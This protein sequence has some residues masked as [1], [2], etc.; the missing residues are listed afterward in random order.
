[1]SQKI[2]KLIKKNKN[3]FGLVLDLDY[4]KLPHFELDLSKNNKDFKNLDISSPR[5]FQDYIFKKL[6]QT[7]S[8]FAVGKYNENRCIYDHSNLFSG[9]QR[10]TIHLG[11]DLWVNART[12]VL[13]PF[14]ARAH[15]FNYN[16][17][18]G[19]YGPTIILEHEL[20][21]EKFFTLYGHLSLN[22]LKNIQRGKLFK[23][24][25]II[26]KVGNY[27]VNGNWAPHLHFELITDMQN[28][29][30]DYPGV[31]SIKKRKEFLHLCPNPNL[32]LQIK[33]LN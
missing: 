9:S 31:T 17:S 2:V 22:S 27:P 30:G 6:N 5:E 11:I 12:K 7:K 32:I 13:C 28:M 8:I 10:R 23:K 14:D 21:G 19:D 1:M 3:K 15:S 24:G 16:D 29:S 25:Q 20:E 33:G 4:R 18:E 26:G